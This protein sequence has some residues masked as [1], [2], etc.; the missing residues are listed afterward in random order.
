MKTIFTLN[1]QLFAA[2]DR[3]TMNPNT[4]ATPG[5]SPT[6]KDFYDTALLENARAVMVWEQFA[7]RQTTTHGKRAEWRRFNTFAPATTP[8][9]EAQAP[10]GKTFGMSTVTG[11]LAQYGDFTTVSDVLELTAFDDVIY[12]ATEEMGA[13]M[14][15]TYDVLTRDMVSLGNS[16]LYAPNISADGEETAVTA[17]SGLNGTSRLTPAVV[18]KAST[19]LKKHRAPK[20]NGYF[21]AVIHPSVSHDLMESAEWKEFQKYTTSDKI[22]KGEIGELYGIKFI[23]TDTAKIIKTGNDAIYLTQFFGKDAFGIIDLEGAGQE[24]IIHDKSEIGGPIDQY[25]TIGYKF[26]HGGAILHQERML[27]VESNS[28][29]SKDDVAN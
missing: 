18:H 29:F 16:V 2:G 7:K 6:M 22:F 28:S 23:E 4:T 9:V 17:R 21:A 26:M 19:W 5:M 10:T 3:A 12:G 20:I 1:L 25:S 24:M 13:S 15:E 11:D 27:R 8:L 14:G